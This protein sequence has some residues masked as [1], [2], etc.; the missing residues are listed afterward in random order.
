MR[1]CK[2]RNN[3]YG[4]RNP[5]EFALLKVHSFFFICIESISYLG[6]QIWNMVPL[7]MKKFTTTNAFKSKVK[8]WK[9]EN[10]PCKLGKPY[11]QSVGFF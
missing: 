11:I 6:P 2:K 10:C 9:L 4:L 5:S 7:E 3:V 8:K 1:Y